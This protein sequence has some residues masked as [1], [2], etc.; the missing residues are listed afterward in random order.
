MDPKNDKSP[1]VPKEDANADDSSTDGEDS[2]SDEDD[3]EKKSSQDS[4][5]PENDSESDSDKE[6]SGDDDDDP[7]ETVTDRLRLA[8]RQALGD[9]G[10]QTDDEDI[11]VDQIDEDQGKRLDE[12]LAAA[13]RILRENRQTPSKKQEKSAEALTHFRVRVMDLLETYVDSGPSMGLALDMLVP[14]FALLEYCIKDPHQKPLECRVRSCLKKLAAVKKFKD[15]EG[16]DAQLLT[17]VLKLLMEKGERSTAIC[18]EMGDK[19]AECATFLVK[20][21]QHAGLP[22]ETLVQI[23]G[24]NLTAFFKKRDCVLPANLFR[25]ALQIV[26][27]GNWQLAPL[28]VRQLFFLLFFRL[29]K[30]KHQRKG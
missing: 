8:V 13:F 2:D 15:T 22:A 10:V 28:L 27:D 20:C 5:K 26:W 1:L 12:S 24:E 11:D 30:L 19:L 3:D 25:N 4:V 7:D 6:T 29:L 21:V 14:L 16:V 17:D 23:Y 18:Q 9:A